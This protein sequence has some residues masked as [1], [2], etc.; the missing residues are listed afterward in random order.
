MKPF[1]KKLQAKLINHMR[2]VGYLNTTY[3]EAMAKCHIGR[4]QWQCSLCKEIYPNRK[5]LHGDHIDCCIDPLTGFVD[6]NTY[7][8]RLFLGQ[9]QGICKAK[10]HAQKTLA[11]NQIRKEKRQQKK[12]A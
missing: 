2:R 5:D 10:C 7:L 3:A 8:E 9:I 4:G 11:E 1:P 6:F 12:S